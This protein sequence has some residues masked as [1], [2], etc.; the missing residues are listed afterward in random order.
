MKNYSMRR[1]MDVC[2]SPEHSF[3]A[4]EAQLPRGHPCKATPARHHILQLGFVNNLK[5]QGETQTENKQV[6]ATDFLLSASTSMQSS[7][8][9]LLCERSPNPM[10]FPRDTW[11]L[12]V[13][14]LWAAFSSWVELRYGSLASSLGLPSHA[15]SFPKKKYEAAYNRLCGQI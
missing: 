14:A 12:H 1:L 9:P 10:V 6:H 5:S 11:V 15:H 7:C 4:S 13:W 8:T 3:W 2:L